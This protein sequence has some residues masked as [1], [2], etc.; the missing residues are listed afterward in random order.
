MKEKLLYPLFGAALAV[1]GL[2]GGIGTS[3][4]DAAAADGNA[5][6]F[7]FEAIEGGPL[8]LAQFAGKAI[9]IVNT[10]SECGFTPQYEGL[11]ELWRGMRERGLVVIGVPSNDFGGQEPGSAEEI[12]QF[13]EGIYRVDFPLAQKTVVKGDAAHPFYAWARAALGSENA[14]RWNFHKYLVGPDGSLVEAFGTT[15]RPND[16]KIRAAVERVLA[17]S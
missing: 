15:V 3:G 6:D 11:Q 2:F 4:P 7:A 5:H 16:P 9:L 8:P 14:P 1:G 10:A 13:C 12:K 17:G